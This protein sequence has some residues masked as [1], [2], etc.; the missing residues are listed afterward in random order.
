MGVLL[1]IFTQSA[2]DTCLIALAIGRMALE[3]G[4]HVGINPQRELL[5]DGPKKQAALRAAQSRT[6]GMSRVLI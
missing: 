5:L 6:S 2:I 3:P 4:D 1:H